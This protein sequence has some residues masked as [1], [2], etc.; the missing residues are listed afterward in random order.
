VVRRTYARDL[1]ASF[2]A[3]ATR[4]GLDEGAVVRLRELHR[5]LVED[6][7]AATAVRDPAKV[8]DDHLAD[9][10]VALEMDVVRGARD[11]ADLGSGA[12][13]PGLPLA[14]VLPDARVALVESAARKCAFLERAVARCAATN[15]RVVHARAESWPEGLAAFD[16][17]TARAL[18][19]FEVVVEYAAPLLTVGG[20]LVAWR[21]RRDR[22]AESTAA[23]AARELGLEPA[24]IMPV[25]PYS[26]V[27]SRYLHLMSKVTETPRGF[28]RR[29]GAALKRPLG[30]R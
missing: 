15:A 5:L 7:L 8:I 20:T 18:A 14:V 19:P 28:P 4:Y 23:L 27:Q 13:L 26:A 12:G 6:P 10:L 3:L 30:A 9:S 25:K 11:I 24:G 2:D 29:P 16:V 1:K 22:A 17:V 21:G